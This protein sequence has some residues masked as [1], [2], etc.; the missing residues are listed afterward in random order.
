MLALKAQPQEHE[1]CLS[2]STTNKKYL[3]KKHSGPPHIVVC[4]FPVAEYV[5]LRWLATDSISFL[6]MLLCY[7]AVQSCWSEGCGE[8]SEDCA[9]SVCVGFHGRG[10][11]QRRG[12][13]E[14]ACLLTTC[15]AKSRRSTRGVCLIRLMWQWW[16]TD[17][18]AVHLGIRD[19]F[20]QIYECRA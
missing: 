6:S 11:R 7:K 4:Q 9:S 2:F 12:R 14:V 13:G 20:W 19:P 16:P 8:C 1:I 5:Y 15:Q 17:W 18:L 3:G 10:V